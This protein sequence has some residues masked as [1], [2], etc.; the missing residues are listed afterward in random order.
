MFL[1]SIPLFLCKSDDFG[2]FSPSVQRGNFAEEMPDVD[3]GMLYDTSVDVSLRVL[4]NDITQPKQFLV[5]ECFN[6]FGIAEE[7]REKKWSIMLFP[8]VLDPVE[9]EPVPKV[10]W[11]GNI[12]V[13][14]QGDKLA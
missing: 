12:V 5:L 7:Q 3:F 13:S 8:V 14:L 9:A 11:V 4:G 10:E 6:C 2:D 1:N